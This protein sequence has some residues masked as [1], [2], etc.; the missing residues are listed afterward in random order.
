MFQIQIEARDGRDVVRGTTSHRGLFGS[1]RSARQALDELLS[2]AA[3][4]ER[5]RAERWDGLSDLELAAGRYPQIRVSAL[6]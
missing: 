3:A 4:P 5:E 6:A 1:S 2:D